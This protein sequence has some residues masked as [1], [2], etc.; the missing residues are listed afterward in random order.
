M[1]AV[2]KTS[3]PA[4]SHAL[5][6][7]PQTMDQAFRMAEIISSSRMVPKHLQ[8]DVGTCFMVVEQSMRWNLSPFAVAQCTSSIGGKLMYEGKLVAAVAKTSNSIT[9]EFDYEFSG[10]PTKPDTLSVT[11][12]AVRASDGQRK[13]ITLKW[14]DAKTTN[15]FWRKQPE[16]QLSYAAARVWCRRWSPGPMLGVYSPEEWQAQPSSGGVV[17]EGEAS[18]ET[19]PPPEP[20]PSPKPMSP[21][22]F[23]ERVEAAVAK[24]DNATKLLGLMRKVIPQVAAMDDLAAVWGLPAVRD[25]WANGPSLI[26]L[27]LQELRKE[28]VDRLSP[29]MD[30]GDG[31]LSNGPDRDFDPEEAEKPWAEGDFP[32]DRPD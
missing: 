17:I 14:S 32:A 11:C 6:L 28:A 29:Q 13:E 5:A 2:A 16:Q 30:V 12:S 9:G 26:R 8:G 1:N 7:I 18:S 24:A 27:D 19:Q 22:T 3:P 4:T 31:E 25:L 23:I 21:L 20:A 15:E 10:D